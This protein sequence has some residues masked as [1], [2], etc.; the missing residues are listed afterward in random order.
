MGAEEGTHDGEAGADDADAGLDAAPDGG[1]DIFPYA[2]KGCH[3][4]I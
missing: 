4:S 2:E 3:I 1:V